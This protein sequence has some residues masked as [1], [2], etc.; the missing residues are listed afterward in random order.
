MTQ[1]NEKLAALVKAIQDGGV[2]LVLGGSPIKPNVGLQ[3]EMLQDPKN[4]VLYP[5][6][7]EFEMTEG[8]V[9]VVVTCLEGGKL[10]VEKVGEMIRK[11]GDGL[12]LVQQAVLDADGN[13]TGEVVSSAT[14]LEG[15]FEDAGAPNS[16]VRRRIARKAAAGK[17]D[18]LAAD[19]ILA[20]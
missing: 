3:T 7:D 15:G 11:T 9:P 19:G 10:Q 16:P 6:S 17:G 4:G 5:R 13:E 2:P 20:G 8:L 18:E 12:L 14:G 1:G